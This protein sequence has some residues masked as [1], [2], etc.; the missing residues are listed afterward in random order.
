MLFLPHGVTA[1]NR[2]GL[3][4]SSENH[5]KGGHEESHRHFLGAFLGASR[6]PHDYGPTLGAEYAFRPSRQLGAGLTAE[7]IGGNV[8][9]NVFVALGYYHPTQA[10]GIFAGGGWGR[11]LKVEQEFD[12]NSEAPHQRDSERLRGRRPLARIGVGY[13]IPLGGAAVF[14]PNISLDLVDGEAVVVFGVTVGFGF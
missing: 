13:E 1:E 10:L 14:A 7:T 4:E 6:L 2:P 3:Q 12:Q 5:E 9:E 8:N 11:R